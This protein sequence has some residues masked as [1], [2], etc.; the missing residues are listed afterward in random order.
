[1]SAPVIQ[2]FGRNDSADTRHCL[3]FFRER[4][5]PVS[6]VDVAKRPLAAAELRR[7]TQRFGARGL[8][9]EQSRAYRE[10]GLGYLRLSDEEIEQRLL[11]Q[12]GLLRLPLVR[13]GGELSIGVDETTWRSWQRQV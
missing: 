7:F 9:D 12:P 6:F 10:A 13:N 5:M 3:R 2:V 8:L 11:A 4:R 1:V